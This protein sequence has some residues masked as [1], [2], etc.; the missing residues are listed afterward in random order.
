MSESMRG[1]RLGAVSYEREE[2]VA[3]AERLPTVYL[4]QAG[5]RTL[6]PFSVEAEEI[7]YEWTCRC[8]QTATRPH[9]QPPAAKPERHLRTHWD[10]LMERRTI[11]D[12]EELLAERLELLHS[13]QAVAAAEAPFP[14]FWIAAFTAVTKVPVSV[15]PVRLTPTATRFPSEKP[16]PEK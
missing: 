5:H 10:M 4:C 2:A 6:V 12:L 3:P 9:V 11:A 7:P 15:T 16:A 13:H 14:A 1:T 8:G